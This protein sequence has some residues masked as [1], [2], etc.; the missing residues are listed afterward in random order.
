MQIDSLDFKILDVLQKDGRITN[1]RLALQVGLSESACSI[2]VKTLE[3]KKVLRRFEARIDQEAFGP[4]IT[5]AACVT[6]GSHR[7]YEADRFEQIVETIPEVVECLFVT[8]Q[9][10]Y[11]LKVVARDM[12]DYLEI[13][14]GLMEGFGKMSQFTSYIIMRRAKDEDPPSSY[15]ARKSRPPS[16]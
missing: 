15:L 10:D 11:M 12:E 16:V 7:R 14:E 2:R 9:F 1:A 4:S 6:L 8:G 3:R 5:I 13:M